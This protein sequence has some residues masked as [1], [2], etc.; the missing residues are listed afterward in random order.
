MCNQSLYKI[1]KD[2]LCSGGLEW[3]GC[4][5]NW[6]ASCHYFF[7]RTYRNHGNLPF[8]SQYYKLCEGSGFSKAHVHSGGSCS[9]HMQHHYSLRFNNIV[10]SP[11]SKSSASEKPTAKHNTSPAARRA[12]MSI[13]SNSTKLAYLITY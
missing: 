10:S 11:S 5:F 9:K 6:S 4:C 7:T 8:K 2:S 1:M 13:K 3:T 12:M